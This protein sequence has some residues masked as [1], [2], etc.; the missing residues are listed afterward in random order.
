[1]SAPEPVNVK[2]S[3]S[4]PNHRIK[5]LRR[6]LR[7]SLHIALL[8]KELH[9]PDAHEIYQTASTK[10]RQNIINGLASLVMA[11][12]YL[13]RFSGLY[14]T[15]DHGYDRLTHA[16][17]TRPCLK[18][19]VWVFKADD[20]G[21]D[22][23]GVYRK[24]SRA[25]DPYWNGDNVD[26]FLHSHDNWA[27]LDTLCLFGQGNCSMM[28]Y[29]AF[30]ATFRNL[31][32]LKHLKISDFE[33]EQFND[34]TLQAIPPMKSLRLQD[35]PGLTEKG[36]IRFANSASAK[37]IRSLT[38]INLEIT[39]A[40]VISRY[41]ANLPNLCRFV[42]TQEACP[43][44]A[45]GLDIPS[46]LYRSSTLKYLHWDVLAY[47]PSHHDLA[48]SIAAGGMPALRTI[49]A[50]SDDEGLLQAL[51][52]PRAQITHPRDLHLVNQINNPFSYS[53]LSTSRREAQ[54]R[55]EDARNIP[56]MKIVVDEEGEMQH[57]YTIWD[58][59]GTLGSKIEYVLEPDIEGSE[60]P[61]AGLNDLLVRREVEGAN[62]FC[63]AGGSITNDKKERGKKQ[64]VQRRLTRPLT[65]DVFF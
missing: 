52:R 36:L 4:L 10:D 48:A 55:L 22:D 25:H 23:N 11:C 7:E 12:P 29:R 43:T 6:T 37:S 21:W 8:V 24:N 19:K 38:L 39:S 15:Y 50:P 42:L 59:M 63:Y 1:M 41:L 46:I 64:H 44:L 18:E 35:L 47:G 65:L 40:V 51:C 16:L 49:C 34:R 13:E 57:T 3:R 27:C 58:Y 53:C 28:D 31:P 33:A 5:T 54:K 17:T 32:S 60:E 56:L 61:L 62:K 26:A 30:I 20:V 14:L 9:F 45:P 2:S